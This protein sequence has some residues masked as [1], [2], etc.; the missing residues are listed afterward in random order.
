L[1]IN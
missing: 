1:V